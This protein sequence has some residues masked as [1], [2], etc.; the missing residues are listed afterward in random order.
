MPRLLAGLGALA[1]LAGC[2]TTAPPPEPSPVAAAGVTVFKDGRF[3]ALIGPRRQHA[4][5]FLDVADTNYYLLRGFIDTKSGEVTHQLYVQYSYFGAPAEW[6]DARDQADQQLRFTKLNHNEITCE[7]GCS[8]ADE[9]AAAL[10][11]PLLRQSSAGLSVTFTGDR[12]IKKT[13]AVD[14]ALIATELGAVD[15]VRAKLASAAAAAPAAPTPT[16]T[17]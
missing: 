14:G 3:L 6:K 12:G 7:S 4:E 17:P 10:P 1:L 13:I 15:T 2:A 11:E 9:F 16:T 5:P 8:Y